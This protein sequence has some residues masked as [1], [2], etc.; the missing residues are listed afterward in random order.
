MAT[1]IKIDGIDKIIIESLVNDAR[2]PILT[3]AK[4][5]EFLVLPSTKD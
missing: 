4:K 5:L 3:I 1:K 2:T